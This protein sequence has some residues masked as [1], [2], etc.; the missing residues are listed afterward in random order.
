M[1][2]IITSLYN[3]INNPNINSVDRTI[4][5]T[6]LKDY[7]QIENKTI[8]QAAKDLHVTPSQLS[9]FIR[10]I[11]FDSY[12]EFRQSLT[13]H[14][15]QK[16]HSYIF[17]QSLSKYDI[18]KDMINEINHFY[19]HI[20]D[21][22]IQYLVKNINEYNTIAIFGT[23]SSES[24]ANIL[25][26]HLSR[27]NII[28]ISYSHIKDQLDFIKNADANTLI[29]ILSISGEY[30]LDNNY[31]RYL[32]TIKYLK[33]TSAKIVIITNNKDVNSFHYIDRV[34][35]LPMLKSHIVL[36]LFI[37]LLTV[38]FQNLEL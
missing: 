34:I 12:D 10:V 6:L 32:K 23:L 19:T 38:E 13:Y 7:K 26:Y 30:V 16:R 17:N 8:I 18:Q 1:N 25:Q 24:Y 20:N 22:D 31:N 3:L 28:S 27:F 9:R 21:E 11:G 2:L 14:G 37:D 4:A 36:S 29:I 33:E 15:N 5:Y 35:H